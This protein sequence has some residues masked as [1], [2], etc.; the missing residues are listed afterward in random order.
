MN[1]FGFSGAP[2]EIQNVGLL[3]QRLAIEWVRDNIKGFGGD[4]T[5]ITLFGQ[6]AGGVSVD[7]YSYIWTQD[8]IVHG[9]ISQSGTAFSFTPNSLEQSRAS[10]YNA[11]SA[12]GCG[13]AANVLNCMRS[14]GFRDIL[15]AIDLIAPRP[16][17]ALPA[18]VFQPTVDNKTVF[19][20]YNSLAAQDEFIKV[21]S[22]SILA[23]IN[24]TNVFGL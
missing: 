1:I 19:S 22:H 10:F 5:R 4:P 12:L 18:P 15:K 11:S 8:P 20:D 2:D 3:D 16:T 14:K 23:P 21:V 13:G 7:Y 17:L 24:H 9:L 6:S